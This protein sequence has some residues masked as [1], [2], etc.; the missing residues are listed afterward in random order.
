MPS[1]PSPEWDDLRDKIIGLGEHSIR[2]SYYPELEQRIDELERFRALLDQ[3]ND[4]I[5]LV[6]VPAG[7]FADM[8]GAACRQ[9]GHSRE[10]LLAMSIGD[11]VPQPIWEKLTALFADAGQIGRDGVTIVTTF[12]CGG[13]AIP[14]ELSVRL[15]DFRDAVYAVIVARDL[16]QRKQAEEEIRYQAN[17]LANVSD[18][19]ISTDMT[20]TIKSWNKAAETLYG[21]SA[22]EVIGKKMDEVVPTEYLAGRFKDVINQVRQAGQWQ[23]EVMQWD[24]DGTKRHILS[25]VT[26][27]HNETGVVAVNRDITAHK[28][29]E[30]ENEELAAQFYQAQK[31]DSIGRL[32][33]GIAHDFNNLLVPII[34]YSELGMLELAPDSRL[35][36]DLQRIRGAAERAANLTR[37][38]L[39][40]SR[41]QML[42]IRSVDLNEVLTNFEPMLGRL[43]GEDIDLRLFLASALPPVKADPSQ[44][45]QVIL[46]M[47]VNARDAMPQGGQLSLETD[48]VYLDENYAEKRPGCTPGPHVLLAVSDTGHGMDAETQPYIFDPFFTTKEQGTGLGLAMVYGVVKQHG[49]HIWVYSELNRG[50]TFKIYLPQTAETA[51][52]IKPA[53]AESMI[54]YGTET[55]LVVEDEAMVRHLVVETL[56]AHGYQVL[57]AQSPE[58]SLQLATAYSNPIH[59][60]LSDVIMPEMNGQELYQRIA[61]VR[62]GIKALYMSGYTNNVIAHHDILREGINFLQK[63]F[64]IRDLTRK[65]RQALG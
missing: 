38:I 16:T 36:I 51:Q 25:S 12:A 28:Q 30:A 52:Q 53:G 47:A 58:K 39:A 23:G 2:K 27:L 46:N 17:L 43:I 64:T 37:Q 5:F 24:K 40:F 57:Q 3:S 48:N 13:S 56:E 18:A 19:I 63:P 14:V 59:L 26:L 20:F 62:P 15:V 49:G 54:L 7:Q 33:G 60:L 22:Q 55:I 21:W 45:E 32:A 11:L 34:G 4:L 1:E 61:E 35:Y 65:V 31:M 8:N 9:L 42:D 50:T 41:K 6:Q 29:L 44:L 10:T